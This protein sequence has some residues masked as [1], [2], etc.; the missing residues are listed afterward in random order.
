MVNCIALEL[1][2]FPHTCFI[3]FPFSLLHI[4]VSYIGTQWPLPRQGGWWWDRTVLAGSAKN[5]KHEI[6]PII[7]SAIRG[8]MGVL[9]LISVKVKGIQIQ[10]HFSPIFQTFS[11]NCW[12]EFPQSETL[13]VVASPSCKSQT[14]QGPPSPTTALIASQRTWIS[15][16]ASGKNICKK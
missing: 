1:S 16:Q 6:W 8:G 7:T 4:C 5:D 10:S 13:W 14:W 2:S 11:T 9:Y 15:T 3:D 12:P